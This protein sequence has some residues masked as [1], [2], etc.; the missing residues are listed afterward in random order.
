MVVTITADRTMAGL[1]KSSRTS[2]SW[3]SLYVENSSTLT[4]VCTMPSDDGGSVSFI[5]DW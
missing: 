4:L 5:T 3:I 1:R 2:L